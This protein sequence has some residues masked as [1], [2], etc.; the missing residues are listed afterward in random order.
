[1]LEDAHSVTKFRFDSAI[2]K[3][4]RYVGNVLM[5]IQYCI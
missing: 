2:E 3:C 5:C 4:P 1:M